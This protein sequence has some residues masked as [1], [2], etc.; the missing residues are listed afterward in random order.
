MMQ[1]IDLGDPVAA[2]TP[3][4]DF[5]D[6]MDEIPMPSMRD[7]I[8][9]ACVEGAIIPF[10]LFTS[11]KFRRVKNALLDSG[12]PIDDSW[13]IITSEEEEEARSGRKE[14]K[15]GHSTSK[16]HSF[17][18]S[19]M[20]GNERPRKAKADAPGGGQETRA[21]ERMQRE[22]GMQ[23][24]MPMEQSPASP[25]VV[26]KSSAVKQVVHPVD[27]PA[28]KP[29]VT[30]DEATTKPVKK[31]AEAPVEKVIEKC[32]KTPVDKVVGEVS[33]KAVEKAVEKPVEKVAENAE[34][35]SQ[36]AAAPVKQKG[37]QKKKNRK[38]QDEDWLKDVEAAVQHP[39]PPQAENKLD[40]SPYAKE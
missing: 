4:S 25:K 11:R 15:A 30:V 23:A 17:M 10:S 3:D 24:N 13:E 8:T 28:G 9:A 22:S 21:Q 39:C 26:D 1:P 19:A 18:S 36:P 5:E 12:P 37:K 20:S 27:K 38:Y 32:N 29:P 2:E 35:S 33:E 31:T 7:R 40:E 6:N 34:K 16:Y 14:E